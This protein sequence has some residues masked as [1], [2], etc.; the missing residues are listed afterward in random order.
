MSSQKLFKTRSTIEMKNEWDM[1][2]QQSKTLESCQQSFLIALLNQYNYEITIEPSY[3][4]SKKTFPLF[5][6]SKITKREGANMIDKKVLDEALKESQI[7]ITSCSQNSSQILQDDTMSSQ[8]FSSSQPLPFPSFIDNKDNEF[9]DKTTLSQP[10]NSQNTSLIMTNDK[11]IKRQHKRNVD[12]AISNLMIKF[13]EEDGVMFELK[14]T[15]SSIFTTL[16][17]KIKTAKFD[18]YGKEYIFNLD[19]ITNIGKY[20]NSHI[21]KLMSGMKRKGT[22]DNDQNIKISPF[23]TTITGIFISQIEGILV[24]YNNNIRYSNNSCGMDIDPTLSYH[25][26]PSLMKQNNIN[27]NTSLNTSQ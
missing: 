12:S 3:K 26:L 21:I 13:L 10:M 23:E 6:I 20:V 22:S 8:I 7:K 5:S 2:K 19:I 17:K 27:K 1:S 24:E 4:S 15:R 9:D 14:G 18:L 16:M 11:K 25:D